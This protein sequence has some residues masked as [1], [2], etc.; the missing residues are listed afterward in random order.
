MTQY[1]VVGGEVDS[2]DALCRRF[3]D[4]AKVEFVGGYTNHQ[5]ASNAWRARAQQTVD[6][7][8]MRFFI[9]PVD[10]LFPSV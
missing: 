10:L 2:V 4:P 6:N 8:H 1:I 3:R 5:D 7:A 9:M